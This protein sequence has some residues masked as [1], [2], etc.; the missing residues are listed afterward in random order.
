MLNMIN[1]VPALN[2]NLIRISFIDL[3]L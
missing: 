3:S 1:K 2:I